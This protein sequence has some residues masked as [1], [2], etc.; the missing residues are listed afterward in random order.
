MGFGLET[1]FIEHLQTTTPSNYSAIANSHTLQFTKART[2]SSQFG[3]SSPVI[4]WYQLPM[5]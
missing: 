3:V 1:G 4:V 2:K 5:P